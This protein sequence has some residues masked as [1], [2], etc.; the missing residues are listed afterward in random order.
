MED[1]MMI[2]F[3]MLNVKPMFGWVRIPLSDARYY[4]WYGTLDGKLDDAILC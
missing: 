3:L 1:D 4:L 2:G